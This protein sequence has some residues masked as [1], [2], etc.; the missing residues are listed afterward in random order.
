MKRRRSFGNKRTRNAQRSERRRT[1][2]QGAENEA[3]ST[4]ENVAEGR[5]GS[6]MEVCFDLNV[7][8]GDRLFLLDEDDNGASA[9]SKKVKGAADN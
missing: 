2:D 8:T 1:S 5:R 9:Q 4:N 6:P 3:D 7:S